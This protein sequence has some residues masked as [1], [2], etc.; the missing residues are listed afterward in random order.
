LKRQCWSPWIQARKRPAGTLYAT[1]NDLSF[2]YAADYVTN[3]Q[4]F[5]MFPSMPRSLAPF[6]FSGLGQFSDSAP[7]RWGRKVFARSLNR[8][9]VSESEYLFGVNDLTRQGA[10]RFIIDWQTGGRRRRGAGA[11]QY[12]RAAEH[13]RRGGAEI[14][15]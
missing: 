7:D 8:T 3:P 4:A 5:D 2:R 14:A 9:R 6:Y 12:A 11:G 10:V 1:G 15:M 13:R